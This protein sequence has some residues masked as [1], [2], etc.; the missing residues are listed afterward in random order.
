MISENKWEGNFSGK[1]NVNCVRC[2]ESQASKI[3][4]G[5]FEQKYTW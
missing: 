3:H 2:Y 4:F 5:K 1:R